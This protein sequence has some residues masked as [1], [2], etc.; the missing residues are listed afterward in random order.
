MQAA[1]RTPPSSLQS[2]KAHR[3]W[4]F[5]GKRICNWIQD[6]WFWGCGVIYRIY[7]WIIIIFRESRQFSHFFQKRI[8]C[9]FEKFDYLVMNQVYSW[10][11]IL[12]HDHHSWRSWISYILDSWSSRIEVMNQI[13]A[14]VMS[15]AAIENR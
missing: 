13:L 2:L 5:E 11:M 14:I 6:L 3:M 8:F 10:F 1:L 4:E 7:I 9:V 15:I 12:I